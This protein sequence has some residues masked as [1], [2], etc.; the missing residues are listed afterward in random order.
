MRGPQLTTALGRVLHPQVQIG[1][2]CRIYHHVT[3]AAE[4]CIGSDYKIYPGRPCDDRYTH[5]V[6]V[7]ARPNS[8]LKI[9]EG[10]VV[11][12]GSIVTRDILRGRCGP[13]TPHARF[14][15]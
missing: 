9:G 10:S 4:S 8:T 15:T 13:A 11:G 2:H 14:V 12:A 5:A 3:L 6:A 7:I 1:N